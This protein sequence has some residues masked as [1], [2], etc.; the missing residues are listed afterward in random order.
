MSDDIAIRTD[1]LVALED[2]GA[3][4]PTELRLGVEISY[5]RYEAIGAMFGRL[6][7]ASKWWIGDWLNYGEDTFGEEAAQAAEATRRSVETLRNYAW[8][9]RHVSPSRRRDGLTFTHH[10]LVAPLDPAEQAAWLDRAEAERWTSREMGAALKQARAATGIDVHQVIS[11]AADRLAASLDPLGE[12]VDVGASRSRS[13]GA[14]RTGRRR[15]ACRS[16]RRRRA[17]RPPSPPPARSSAAH[18]TAARPS[19]RRSSPGSPTSPA[20]AT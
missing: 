15:R 14:R 13:W 3:L 12:V 7:D 1:L 20:G 2:A 9:C 8:T 18:V 4:T 19:S 5:P 10:V 17:T 11:R 16:S 6:H